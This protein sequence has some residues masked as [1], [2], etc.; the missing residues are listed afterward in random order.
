MEH[1]KILA[2]VAEIERE[3]YSSSGDYSVTDLINPPR[4]VRLKK[5]HM[6][7]AE[8]PLS[9]VIPS[10][11]GTAIHEYFEK[12]LTMW[13][14][15]HKYQNY[16]FEE[17]LEYDVSD[18]KISGRYDIRDG[19]HLYDIKTAKVW[20]KIFDPE[21]I[22][23]HQQQNL[24][25][26]LL[27]KNGTE[28]DSINIVAVYKDWQEGNALRDRTYPQDQVVEHELSHWTREEQERFLL[29][30][31][32]L[33]KACEDVEDHELP[34]CSRSERWE[35]FQGGHEIEF[36]IMK[37][38]TAKRAARVIKTSLE[39]A[40]A[41]ARG[42]KG[43]TTDSFIEVRYAVRKRCEKYCAINGFCSDYLAYDKAKKTNKLNDIMPIVL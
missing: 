18:R 12:Y 17:Q 25:S 32:E 42:M 21:M 35:R 43:I 4:V 38:S 29:E 5:R 24:Y 33:H 13:V 36:V 3:R 10:M 8:Q 22:E 30:R 23:W 6:D 16:T 39:D 1:I 40:Y 27:H 26:Y 9:S 14:L 19:K 20:K 28:L 11:M 7:E 31:L 15:K 2:R 34:L 37:K 41:Y